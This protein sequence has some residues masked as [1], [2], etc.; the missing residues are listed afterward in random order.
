MCLFIYRYIHSC[1]LNRQGNSVFA[2]LIINYA[3]Y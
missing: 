2:A 1:V 3:R